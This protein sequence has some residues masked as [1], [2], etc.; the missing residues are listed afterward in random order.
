VDAAGACPSPGADVAAV[1]PSPGADAAGREPQSRSRC[2]SSGGL[3]PGADAE[4][5]EPHS[6]CSMA[7]GEPSPG[8]DVR[9]GGP[10]LAQMRERQ[11]KSRRRCGGGEPSPGA[12]VAA[13]TPVP[14]QMWQRWALGS[15]EMQT[16]GECAR[17]TAVVRYVA[18]CML[19]VALSERNIARCSRVACY[20]LYT[21]C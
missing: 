14:V 15:S 9:V 18:R 17:S 10:V 2:G 20:M 8:A 12:G 1:S 11:A 16:S 13:E 19:E 3:S 7:G 21:A 5:G 6:Q 4:R